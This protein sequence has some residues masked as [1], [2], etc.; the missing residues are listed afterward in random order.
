MDD[1]LEAVGH[2]R[3]TVPAVPQ[4][5]MIRDILAASDCVCTLPQMLLI[6]HLEVVELLAI[7][8]FSGLAYPRRHRS[9]GNLAASTDHASWNVNLR[10]RHEQTV[11]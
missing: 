4:A 9:G 5:A 2:R 6:R 1:Y 8:S 11:R 3:N 10:Y 7:S